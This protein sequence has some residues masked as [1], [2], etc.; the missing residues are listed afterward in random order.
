MN[1]SHLLYCHC[2]RGLRSS[3]NVLIISGFIT[4]TS[5]LELLTVT[6]HGHV[7]L[8]KCIALDP[9]WL[10]SSP[11]KGCYWCLSVWRL[12]VLGPGPPRSS[13]GQG[14]GQGRGAGLAHSITMVTSSRGEGS[15]TS[16][17]WQL[18]SAGGSSAG[19]R[20][21]MSRGDI[22]ALKWT[23]NNITPTVHWLLL[24]C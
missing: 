10:F 24:K 13:P 3:R 5:H 22:N 6:T 23:F 20:A 4:L 7:I 9:C 1:N 8:K 19:D 21:I 17:Q 18:S 2:L 11:L 16:G 15:P 14:G 12:W